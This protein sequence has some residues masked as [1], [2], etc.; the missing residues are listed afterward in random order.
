M[1]K[2][3]FRPS[4]VTIGCA[5][6]FMDYNTRKQNIGKIFANCGAYVVDEN[7]RVVPRGAP[8]ELIVTGPLVGRGYRNRPEAM[9]AFITWEGERGY[10][11]GDLGEYVPVLV[12]HEWH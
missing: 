2:C 6:R 3:S 11:T 12:N 8:G 5:A 1:S 7:L 4:E 10:R 9:S